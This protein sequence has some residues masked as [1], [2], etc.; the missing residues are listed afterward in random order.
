M[1]VADTR[2]AHRY[3]VAGLLTVEL[4]KGFMDLKYRNLERYYKLYK[5]TDLDEAT[6]AHITRVLNFLEKALGPERKALEFRADV[7]SAYF[8]ASDLIKD[9]AITGR[10]NKVRDF[11]LS[12]LSEVGK[13]KMS[14]RSQ[15]DISAFSRYAAERSASADSKKALAERHNIM[16][17]KF[18]EFLPDLPTKDPHRTFN[19]WQRL[20]IYY[21]DKGI[22][23]IGGEPVAF[24]NGEPDHIVRHADGGP[25]VVSN[26]RWACPRH[27]REI[28]NLPSPPTD[29]IAQG[30]SEKVEFKSSFRWDF[31]TN[32]P[33]PALSYVI[34]KVLSSFMNSSGGTI[35]I[36]V[37]DKSEVLGLEK[38][39]LTFERSKQNKD[40]FELY[41]MQV[42]RN[43]FG[44]EPMRYLHLDF[45][46]IAGKTIARVE[47]EHASIPVY[48][49]SEGKTEFYLR[50]GNASQ[51]LTIDETVRY[52]KSHWPDY[53]A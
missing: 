18:L 11:L 45:P 4:S 43:C 51:P 33:N 52:V 2:F 3:L 1:V 14:S 5:G 40:G 32:S 29:L 22:C 21:R 34:A 8:L 35:L 37:D 47:A 20:A 41:F 23:Q 9:Y 50:V 28:A 27:N 53:R 31:R 36:G 10:E 46:S 48:V 49:K 42:M 7:I 13:T 24:E 19:Y 30:E 17:G 39:Y 16:L 44:V 15:E 26:G 38:D 25:T 12:F 6:L